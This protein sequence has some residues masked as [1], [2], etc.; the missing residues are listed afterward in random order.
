MAA[1]DDWDLVGHET[2]TDDAFRILFD[3]HK[4]FVFRLASTVTG[5]TGL[6]EDVTQEVFCRIFAGRSRWRRRAAFRTLLYRVTLNT[7]RELQ[8]RARRQT[9][10]PEGAA[11]IHADTGET[12][13]AVRDT[14]IDRLEKAVAGLS[15]RQREVLVLRIYEGL[16]VTETAAVLRCREGTVKAHLH[17]AIRRLRDHVQRNTTRAEE[18]ETG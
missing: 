4:D 12:D 17:R 3:R 10:D 6:A 14:T 18:K 11:A 16:S 9:V 1:L 5:N 8:R 7:S 2:E 15:H 13:T